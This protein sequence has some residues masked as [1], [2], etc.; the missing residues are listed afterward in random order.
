MHTTHIAITLLFPLE[1]GFAQILE[2]KIA[3]VL[4]FKDLILAIKKGEGRTREGQGRLRKGLDRFL[5]IIIS[6]TDSE[7][8]F[9]KIILK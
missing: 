6:V 7:T 5:K 4:L 1:T 8:P 3:G 9:L 2:L